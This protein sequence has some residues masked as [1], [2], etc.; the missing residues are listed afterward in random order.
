MGLLFY[1]PYPNFF[2]FRP[3]ILYARTKNSLYYGPAIPEQRLLW[4][5]SLN[6]AER[7]F[8][9]KVQTNSYLNQAEFIFFKKKKKDEKA[10]EV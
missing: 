7:L 6:K 8:P 5:T 1:V 2:Y 9:N 4:I 3:A 10:N